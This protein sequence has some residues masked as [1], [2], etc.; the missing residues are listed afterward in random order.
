MPGAGFLIGDGAGAGE[1]VGDGI[2]EEILGW[3]RGRTRRQS[4]VRDASRSGDDCARISSYFSFSNVGV[5]GWDTVDGG[6]RLWF[7]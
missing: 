7:G 5:D 1:G 4:T 2:A 3:R 6:A